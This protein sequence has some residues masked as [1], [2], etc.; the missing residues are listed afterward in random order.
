MSLSGSSA[1]FNHLYTFRYFVSDVVQFQLYEAL[2]I[3]AGEHSSCDAANEK[4]GVPQLF[5]CD[6]FNSKA[7]GK[8]LLYVAP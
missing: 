6:F 1:C 8:L 2:C 4:D 7:A 5:E 3:A